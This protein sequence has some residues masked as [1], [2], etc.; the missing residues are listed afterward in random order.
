MNI[1]RDAQAITLVVEIVIRPND[2]WRITDEQMSDADSGAQVESRQGYTWFEPITLCED[3]QALFSESELFDPK[4]G[5]VSV[6]S[7]T[8][9][10]A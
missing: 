4:Y 5:T 6:E 7:V 2:G 8:E 3:I 9:V 1:D 10:S